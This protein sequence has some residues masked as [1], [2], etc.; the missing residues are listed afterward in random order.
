MNAKVYAKIM[1]VVANNCN[2][3]EYTQIEHFMR[4]YLEN[5]E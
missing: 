2:D 4:R 5:L 3:R 1:T